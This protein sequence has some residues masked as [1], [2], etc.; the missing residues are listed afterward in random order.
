[1]YVVDGI[2]NNK[3]RPTDEKSRDPEIDLLEIILPNNIESSRVRRKT[4]IGDIPGKD[5]IAV[6]ETQRHYSIFDSLY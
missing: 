6:M 2:D 4:A 5:E 3:Q 1:M